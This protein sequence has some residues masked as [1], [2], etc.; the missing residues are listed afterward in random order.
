MADYIAKEIGGEVTKD[1]FEITT[2]DRDIMVSRDDITFEGTIND[3]GMIDWKDIKGYDEID[4]DVNSQLVEAE[5]NAFN[6]MFM[7]YTGKIK[8][9]QVK[10]LIST[11][12]KSNENYDD[13]KIKIKFLEKTYK[14]SEFED[15]KELINSN[16]TYEVVCEEDSNGITNLI[17]INEL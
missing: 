13:R 3:K 11:V 1:G 7:A 9:N 6:Q 12:Q 5:K 17:E 16:E 2:S 8:G 15:L 4:N 10:I 14:E